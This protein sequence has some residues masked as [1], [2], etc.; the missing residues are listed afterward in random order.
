MKILQLISS[1]G[2]YGAEK[3]TLL[4]SRELQGQGQE[5]YLGLLADQQGKYRETKE[6]AKN[7]GL[8]VQVFPC[9]GRL[10][11]RA[12][13]AIRGFLK[14]EK[15]A[16]LHA[17]GYKANF[18]A[19]AGSAGLKIKKLTTCHNWLGT[20]AK[21]NFYRRLD[22]KLLRFFDTIAVVAETLE[23]QVK[24][25]GVA[26]AKVKLVANGVELRAAAGNIKD[27]RAAWGLAEKNKVIG[28][29][30]RLSSE[31]G[32]D[33]LLAAAVAV[34]EK[35]PNLKIILVG[36][37]PERENL[38]SL[39]AKNNLSDKVIFTGKQSNVRDWLELM[40]I[41]VL[42]SLDEG[43]PLALLEAMAAG[44]P[45]IASRVGAI[46]QIMADGRGGMLV[47]AGDGEALAKAIL[48]LLD[49][50][51]AAGNL[52]KQGREIVSR[53]FSA[54]KMADQYLRIYQG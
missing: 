39:A 19:L 25:S 6:A 11:P 31:K 3:V 48:K 43:M 33:V 53:E 51:V 26:E 22:Q 15:I 23:R 24:S 50:P 9:S 20:S 29:V 28:T 38:R 4:L 46:G 5:V 37:G 14:R 35:Y 1:T 44:R 54:A 8:K 52:A 49:E 13:L 41:F 2:L 21:M 42:P 16:V 47:T 36:D 17:H 10:D 30:G 34:S 18:Y 32:L 45:V 12:I 7:W 27:L 40:D